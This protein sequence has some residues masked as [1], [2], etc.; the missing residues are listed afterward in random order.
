M[1]EGKNNE[2]EREP[3]EREREK[4]GWCRVTGQPTAAED[5]DSKSRTC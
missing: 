1:G 4:L 2:K 5:V 3:L